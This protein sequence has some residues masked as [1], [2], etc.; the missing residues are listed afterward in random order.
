MHG[1]Q[2][3]R[4]VHQVNNLLSVIEI[5]TA[6]ARSADTVEASRSALEM[7]GRCARETEQVVVEATSSSEDRS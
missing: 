7:I 3:R 4:L 2:F 1:E 6:V 5:Q